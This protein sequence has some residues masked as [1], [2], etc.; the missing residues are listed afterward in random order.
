MWSTRR[1]T[2]TSV[3]DTGTTARCA[4]KPNPPTTPCL[5]VSHAFFTP[6]AARRLALGTPR[7][8]RCLLPADIAAIG[9]SDLVA[10]DVLIDA[11]RI[12]AIEPVGRI[13]VDLGPD[14]DA[15]MVLPGMVDCHTH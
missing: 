9:D 14:L 8:P 1:C 7:A 6:P 4:A 12:A 11:G 15:S 3:C 13:P 10:I 5:N 2:R